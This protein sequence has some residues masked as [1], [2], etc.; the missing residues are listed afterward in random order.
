MHMLDQENV[1][2]PSKRI[3]DRGLYTF[4]VLFYHIEITIQRPFRKLTLPDRIGRDVGTFREVVGKGNHQSWLKQNMRV[5]ISPHL[6]NF[7]SRCTKREACLWWNS[8]YHLYWILVFTDE[9]NEVHENELIL[10]GMTSLGPHLGFL[11][12]IQLLFMGLG[13]LMIPVI[14]FKNKS[15]PLTTLLY[16]NMPQNK[17]FQ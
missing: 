13:T 6:S 10:S 4:I 7:D 9:E 12:S 1:F 14:S 16:L 5:Q 2:T 11:I 15:V 3:T 17:S 8:K